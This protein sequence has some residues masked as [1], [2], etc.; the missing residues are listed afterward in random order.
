M[1]LDV[2]DLHI[3]YAEQL[4][5]D[6]ISLSL[7][8]DEIVAVETHVLDGGTSLLKGIAGFL[9][10]VDGDVLLRG[11]NLLDASSDESLLDVSF[12]YENHGLVSLLSVFENIGLPLQYHTEMSES[13]IEEAVGKICAELGV[14]ESL[15]PL[16][17]F[18]LN[19]VQTRMVNLA[20]ALV[21][22]PALLLI[23]ELEGGMPDEILEDTMSRLR[24]RQQRFPMVIIITTS[25]EL[26][27]AKADR[28]YRIA[29][30]K[31][32]ERSP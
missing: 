1:T 31:L 29:D 14:E 24:D 32:V 30:F 26:V 15:Y 6:N 12:V 3:E 22:V 25:S 27:M 4:V 9:N 13:E 16:R 20:R 11:Q 23:D 28:V 19:D 10:G 7:G 2:R 8:D 18:E 17:P 5:F 21:T